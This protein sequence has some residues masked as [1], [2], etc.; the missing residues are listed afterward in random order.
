MTA[1]D[2]LT[3]VA[4]CCGVSIVPN[5]AFEVPGAMTDTRTVTVGELCAPV[6]AMVT[7]PV[8]EP[9]GGRPVGR[10]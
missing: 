3:P 6:A 1:T 8:A 10:G 2:P 4:P 5:G 9:L 7:V